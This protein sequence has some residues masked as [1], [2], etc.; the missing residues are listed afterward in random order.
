MTSRHL[1]VVLGTT[2]MLTAA[3]ISHAHHISGTIYCDTDYDGQIDNPGDSKINNITFKAV[4]QDANP[5]ETFTDTRRIRTASTASGSRRGP[6]ATW[7]CPLSLPGGWTIVLPVGGS[8][9]SRSLRETARPTTRTTSTSWRRA[10]PPPHHDVLDDQLVDG[11]A[12]PRRRSRGSAT[13]TWRSSW[14]GTRSTTTTRR[15]RRTSS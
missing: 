6:T 3:S 2:A 7:S 10:A 8:Y 12:R 15:S 11:G 5:G 9:L 4:S 14:A 13:A 1:A